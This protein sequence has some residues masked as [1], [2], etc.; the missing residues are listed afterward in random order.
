M[1]SG[2]RTEL[3]L[4]LQKEYNTGVATG[5]QW[6]VVLD[7]GI[8]WNA[9]YCMIQRALHLREALDM[10]AYKLRLSKEAF[11]LEVFQHDYLSDDEWK[12][13][14]LMADHL[15]PLFHLTKSLEG[16]ADL[17]EGSKQA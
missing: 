8:R 16:N 9:S 2:K 15:A 4:D 5:K 12:A 10:Y 11:D 14:T 6:K 13:L 3:F 17:Q 1:A 7:G